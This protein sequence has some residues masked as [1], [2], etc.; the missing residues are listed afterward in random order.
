MF[1]KKYRHIVIN[2]LIAWIISFGLAYCIFSFVFL[3]Q[4]GKKPMDKNNISTI[5]TLSTITC[6]TKVKEQVYFKKCK[7]M[8]T[9][10]EVQNK[11]CNGQSVQNL[12]D[13]GWA[14]FYEG[15]KKITIFKELDQLCPDCAT[16]RHLGVQGEFVAVIEGPVGIPG[17]QLE[18]LSIKISSLPHEWQ[19]KVRKGELGFSSEDELLEA[20]DSIDEYE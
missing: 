19:E 5:Q 3:N 17:K 7:H 1:I 16:K 15:D 8:V 14:V 4:A 12:K 10:N 18:V 2:F 6:D 13:Q 11:Y 20:L 9:K